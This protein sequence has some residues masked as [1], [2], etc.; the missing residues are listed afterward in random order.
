M[1]ARGEITGCDVFA[2]L[3]LDNALSPGPPGPRGSTHP[4]AGRADILLVPTIEAGNVLGKA[5]T[6][7]AGTPVAHVID[8]AR[9]PVLI[10][11]PRR[12]GRGQAALHRAGRAWR[13]EGA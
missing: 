10:P 2:P 12:A 9:V 5:F 11:S 7:L 4:V 8:G 3:A 1:A 13:P 6:W